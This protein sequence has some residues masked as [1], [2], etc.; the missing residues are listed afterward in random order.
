MTSFTKWAVQYG[1]HLLPAVPSHAAGRPTS[2]ASGGPKASPCP[3]TASAARSHDPWEDPGLLR[4][5]FWPW[6]PRSPASAFG[7]ANPGDSCQYHRR[8]PRW[9]A[10]GQSRP[11]W[12]C[13]MSRWGLPCSLAF[14]LWLPKADSWS[15][16]R[17]LRRERRLLA[18]RGCGSPHTRWASPMCAARLVNRERIFFICAFGES[19]KLPEMCYL[20]LGSR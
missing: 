7:L 10:P 13:L 16:I 20:P 3:S 6:W 12:T 9:G 15:D 2:L 11:I 5:P 14:S 1:D 18:Y 8:L 17:A 4:G 19:T